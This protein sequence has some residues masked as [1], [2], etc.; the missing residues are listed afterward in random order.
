MIIKSLL[1]II[2]FS[3]L[4]VVQ[5]ASAE[6]GSTYV[7]ES[8]TTGKSSI[9]HKLTSRSAEVLQARLASLGEPNAG[10]EQRG[11][12][13]IVLT[14]S[15]I[16]AETAG[17]VKQALRQ[18]RLEF[19]A[20]DEEAQ[21]GGSIPRDAEILFE[22]SISG[23]DGK[24]KRTPYVLKKQAV[25]SGDIIASAETLPDSYSQPQVYVILNEEG[26]KS[27]ADITRRMTGRRLAIVV[28]NNVI[29]APSIKESIS[30]GKLAITGS[31]SQQE[32]DDIVAALNSNY[33]PAELKVI[34]QRDTAVTMFHPPA[35]SQEIAVEEAR[36]SRLASEHENA[37]KNADRNVQLYYN[38]LISKQAYDNAQAAQELAAANAR[39]SRQRLKMLQYAARPRFVLDST[40]RTVAQKPQSTEPQQP[41]APAINAPADDNAVA[42]VIGIEKYQSLP[43]ADYVSTDAARVR[44]YLRSMGY[45]E[46]NIEFLSNERATFSRIRRAFESWLPNRVNPQSRVTV[47][48]AGHGAPDPQSGAAYIVPYDG[49]PSYLKDTGYPLKQLYER[50]ET[51]P[52]KQVIVLIDACFSGAGGRG[53]LAAGARSLVR[54]EKTAI[55]GDR[56]AV[57]T[58][59]Q[60]TQ[61]STSS[62]EKKQG[63]FTYYLLEA[64]QQ[65]KRDLLSAYAYLKPR[66]E[67]EA[68]RLNVEQSPLLSPDAASLKGRFMFW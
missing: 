52:A 46:R 65:G 7:L 18:S 19:R 57:L 28:D 20:V 55:R 25:L 35:K 38:N 27:F 10:V 24:L 5:T 21:P 22:S 54:V 67:D 23:P 13:R 58:S 12:L 3:T 60:G 41:P 34:S 29:S 43:A 42:V 62:P 56:L 16:T 26:A 51:L 9:D 15:R 17:M 45:Q 37:V 32:A 61:I 47:Y 4:L 53:A 49:D 64:L 44:D 14:L 33:L 2:W 11:N 40:P 36:L 66:V 8:S 6:L 63:I 68:K 59:T 31:F 1:A 30:G 50:L 48:Y 39:E